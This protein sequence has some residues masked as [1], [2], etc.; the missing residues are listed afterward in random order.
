MKLSDT[1]KKVTVV[2]ATGDLQRDITGVNIDSRQVKA[3]DLF[4]AVKVR[5]PMDMSISPRP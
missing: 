1:L 4:I 2:A 5:R 3:G